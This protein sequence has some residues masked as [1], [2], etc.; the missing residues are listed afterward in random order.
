MV[1]KWLSFYAKIS[2]ENYGNI[3]DINKAKFKFFKK[4]VWWLGRETENVVN[5]ERANGLNT[6]TNE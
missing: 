5:K 4:F 6:I 2:N 1:K 3:Q